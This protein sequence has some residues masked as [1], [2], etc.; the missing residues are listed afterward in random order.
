MFGIA[1]GQGVEDWP[2]GLVF[3]DP[4]TGKFS[5]LDLGQ[6]FLHGIT[7]LLRD[8]TPPPRDITILRR[9]ADRVTHH[10]NATLIDEVDDQLEL[11]KALKVCDLW[12]IARLHQGVESR[13]DQL[14]DPTTQHRLF[15]EQIS[16]RLFTE[17]GL[18]DTCLRT[19][20]SL[21]ICEGDALRVASRILMDG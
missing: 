7:R 18:D 12:L 13:P 19:S 3:H 11:V 21:G 16:F 20:N 10:A 8:H 15:T 1:F 9:V 5:R 17:G 2:V 4:F 14:S 6:E